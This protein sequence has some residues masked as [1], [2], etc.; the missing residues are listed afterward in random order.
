MNKQLETNRAQQRFSDQLK[1]KGL[2]QFRPKWPWIGGDLQ[3]LRATLRPDP[4]KPEVIDRLLVDLPDGHGQLNCAIGGPSNAAHSLVLFHGLGGHEDSVYMMRVAN[5]FHSA[6]WRTY[7][8]NVRGVG[9]SRK[10]SKGPYSGGL[11]D[12][13]RA[14]LK[15]VTEREGRVPFAMGFSLGGQ[16]L[17]RTLGESG[18]DALAYCQ[19]AVT[20]SAPINLHTS[21]AMLEKRRNAAYQ[22][23]LVKQMHRDLGPIFGSRI[24]S[25]KTIRQIDHHLIAPNFG[26]DSAEAYYDGIGCGHVTPKIMVPTLAIHAEDDPWIPASDYRQKGYF[27]DTGLVLTKLLPSGGHV[28]FVD[29]NAGDKYISDVSLNFYIVFNG[30]C[31]I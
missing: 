18:A 20:V 12:D 17:M 26:Y 4:P 1:A 29:R 30:Q 5:D 6:G 10:T 23:Y 31:H 19:A 3:T 27:P 28:G 14:I 7:R 24:E 25:L 21:V 13:A 16:L 11:T 22:N 9:P 15:A 8:V 2:D